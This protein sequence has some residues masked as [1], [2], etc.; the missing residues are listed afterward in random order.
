MILACMPA[1]ARAP[2]CYTFGGQTHQTLDARI[3]AQVAQTKGLDHHLL[4]I[5]ADFVSNFGRYVDRTVCITDGCAGALGAHEIYLTALARK[6]S[7][8]RLT[9]NYRK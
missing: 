7:P 2:I 8:I 4:R 5:D 9:G 6:I 3:G 1:L